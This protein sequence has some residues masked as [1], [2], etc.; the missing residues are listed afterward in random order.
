MSELVGKSEMSEEDIK[1][2]YITPAIE[3]KWDRHTQIRME[4]SFTD[5]R[6]IVRGNIVA[7]GKRKKADYRMPA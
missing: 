3:K 5:G 4:Y 7:R 1:L 6:V 2:R